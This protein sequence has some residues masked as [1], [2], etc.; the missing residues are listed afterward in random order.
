MSAHPDSDLLPQVGSLIEQCSAAKPPLACDDAVL[1]LLRTLQVVEADRLQLR[2]ELHAACA[3]VAEL[4][5]N[6]TRWHR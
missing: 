2:A 4:E 5:L 6:A 3:R 1:N